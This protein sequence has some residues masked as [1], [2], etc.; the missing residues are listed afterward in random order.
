[1]FADSRIRR[2]VAATII[3]PAFVNLGWIAAGRDKCAARGG[4]AGNPL[5]ALP[6]TRRAVDA[7]AR[8]VRE[9]SMDRK[10]AIRCAFAAGALSHGALCWAQN[11]PADATGQPGIAEVVVTG[12]RIARPEL[13]GSAPIAVVGRDD[14]DA[15][16]FE[17]FADL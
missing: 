4:P 15:Q 6:R 7:T 11:Q 10:F 5:E 9:Q 1:M 12:S 2:C 13:E 16:G 3:R 14:F 8:K 17:N